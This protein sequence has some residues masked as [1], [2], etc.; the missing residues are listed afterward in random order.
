MNLISKVTAFLIAAAALLAAADG[1][2]NQ[3]ESFTCK[4]IPVRFWWCQEPSPNPSDR[5]FRKG[6]VIVPKPAKPEPNRIRYPQQT[7]GAGGKVEAAVD[8]SL[9]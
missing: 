7:W 1:F 3:T 8:G 2:I 6:A 5:N 9:P 4:R